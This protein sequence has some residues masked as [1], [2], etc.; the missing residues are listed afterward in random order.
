MRILSNTVN[1]INIV[2]S[3]RFLLCHIYVINK[4]G[5]SGLVNLMFS[6]TCCA[7][8]NRSHQSSSGMC[9]SI[10]GLLI[11]CS[12]KHMSPGCYCTRMLILAQVFLILCTVITY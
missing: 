5:R 4:Q 9:V 8:R 11:A 10:P 1:D 7:V 2:D 12:H 3:I 6:G